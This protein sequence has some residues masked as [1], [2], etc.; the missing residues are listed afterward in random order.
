MHVSC[1]VDEQMVSKDTRQKKNILTRGASVESDSLFVTM[2]PHGNGRNN[3]R[4]RDCTNR[5]SKDR[6]SKGEPC[7]FK[8]DP[9][10]EAK[11]RER[12]LSID[13]KKSS[14]SDGKEDAKKKIP[15]GHLRVEEERRAQVPLVQ[16]SE[17]R[18]EQRSEQR[19]KSTG[20]SRREKREK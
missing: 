9:T 17:R 14:R 12:S 6:C 15:R 13:S 3:R 5:L 7:R 20:E 2:I 11:R 19:G 16:F 1:G 10:S 4:I 18:S 8:D